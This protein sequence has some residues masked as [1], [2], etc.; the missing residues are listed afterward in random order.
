MFSPIKKKPSLVKSDVEILI[1]DHK[2]DTY[3]GESLSL[4]IINIEE[5]NCLTNKKPSDLVSC[6]LSMHAVISHF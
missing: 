4:V 2:E 1:E 6:T 3:G 5:N